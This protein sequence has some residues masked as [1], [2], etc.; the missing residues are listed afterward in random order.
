MLYTNW[1]KVTT[2]WFQINMLNRIGTCKTEKKLINFMWIN[3]RQ[4]K[5]DSQIINLVTTDEPC[6]VEVKKNKWFNPKKKPT[7]HLSCHRYLALKS[8]ERIKCLLWVVHGNDFPNLKSL[9]TRKWLPNLKSVKTRKWL[10]QTW[11]PWKFHLFNTGI[12]II[13]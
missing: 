11:N 7:E 13:F 6:C 12:I 2:F 4:K 9:K 8:K 10:F 5:K 1:L 3:L